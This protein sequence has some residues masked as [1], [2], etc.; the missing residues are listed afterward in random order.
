MSV[1]ALGHFRR[2]LWGPRRVAFK[3][4]RGQTTGPDAILSTFCMPGP[5][6]VVE[7]NLAS[8]FLAFDEL[9]TGRCI[10]YK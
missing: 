9:F 3:D 7:T 5:S 2:G 8:L 6:W 10:P 4:R 1:T